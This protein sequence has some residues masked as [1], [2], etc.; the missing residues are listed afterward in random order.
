M[1]ESAFKKT[2]AFAVS[3]SAI[4]KNIQKTSK[5]I[6]LNPTGYYVTR[7]KSKDSKSNMQRSHMITRKTHKCEKQKVAMLAKQIVAFAN[8]SEKLKAA[9]RKV[10]Q[11]HER[12]ANSVNT[13]LH[14]YR[15]TSQKIRQKY[16]SRL[17]R[18]KVKP[19]TVALMTVMFPVMFS[20][21]L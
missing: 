18:V 11:D 14:N 9:L 5:R 17:C 13:C 3:L 6:A 12:Q 21:I 10:Q 7:G 16:K 8:E 15:K 4:S 19:V 20:V 1:Q 2:D